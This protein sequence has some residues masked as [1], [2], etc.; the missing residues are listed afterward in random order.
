M[1]GVPLARIHVQAH[2]GQPPTVFVN[3]Q[4]VD[5]AHVVGIA[6]SAEPGSIPHLQ[7][8]HRGDLDL[9]GD[10]IVQLVHEDGGVLA[11]MVDW[12]ESLDPQA[13]EQQA[14]NAQGWGSTSLTEQIISTMV[15]TAREQ[16]K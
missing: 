7:L 1:V 5:L 12:L 2:A 16:L 13:I 10:G 9:M 8:V 14:M 4:P 11:T 6:W 3:D 15:E